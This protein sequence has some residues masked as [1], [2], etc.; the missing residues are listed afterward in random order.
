M[1]YNKTIF[2]GILIGSGLSIACRHSPSEPTQGPSNSAQSGS[3]TAAMPSTAGACPAK[4]QCG[5]GRNECDAASTCGGVSSPRNPF[6]CCCNDA[7]CT[8]YAWRQASQMWRD[9]VPF[10]RNAHAWAQD[11]RDHQYQVL[12]TPAVNTIAVNTSASHDKCTEGGVS[13]DCGHVAWVTGCPD[14]DGYLTVDEMSCDVGPGGRQSTRYK[15]SYFDGGFIY[16]KASGI[17]TSC[18]QSLD[19]NGAIDVR[20]TLEGTDWTGSVGCELKGPAPLSFISV[21]VHFDKRAVGDYRVE[22]SAGPGE[23]RETLATQHL[24]KGAT[25]SFVLPFQGPV[26]SQGGDRCAAT[27]TR[28]APTP[29][30]ATPTNQPSQTATPQPQPTSAT[31]VSPTISR[32]NPSRL[33]GQ[34]FEMTIS[35]SGFDSG[36][37]DEV[38]KP[39]AQGGGKIGEGQVDRRSSTEIRTLQTM[40]GAAPGDYSVR[41]RNSD[42]AV[43][44]KATFTLYDEVAVSPSIGAVGTQFAYTGRGFTRSYGVTSHLTG[45]STL[46]IPTD[47][48]G[49]FTK[50]ID[51]SSLAPGMYEL[52]ADDDATGISSGHVSFQVQ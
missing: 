34:T 15:V 11:A 44:G 7:N 31:P 32:V 38:F 51:S 14:K 1:R 43:S 21:P 12:S 39:S 10:R 35:G 25:I 16:P 42:G 27:P 23:I 30:T 40:T 17:T 46:P 37:Q 20:A 19:D 6:P 33:I 47:A 9:D 24:S 5:N 4:Y 41:V 36:A 18:E 26:C 3:N 2:A 48:Q 50:N 22:C 28:V 8:W 49:Q 13:V 45:H 52:W 29:T